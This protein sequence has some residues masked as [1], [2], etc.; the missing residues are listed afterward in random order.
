MNFYIFQH[1]C[2]KAYYFLHTAFGKGQLVKTLMLYNLY[3]CNDMFVCQMTTVCVF[4]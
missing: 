1:T 2:V 3:T 4:H